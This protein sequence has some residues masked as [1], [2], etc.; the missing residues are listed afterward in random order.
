MRTDAHPPQ[1]SEPED[2]AS[3]AL[4][5]GIRSPRSHPVEAFCVSRVGR[6]RD[7]AANEWMMFLDVIKMGGTAENAFFR[8]VSNANG[9]VFCLHKHA[10]R[11]T[12]CP[13]T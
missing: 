12:L 7:R 10:S 5:Q 9:A 3:Q 1:L 8:P 6:S 2:G 13:E 11:K 4:Q